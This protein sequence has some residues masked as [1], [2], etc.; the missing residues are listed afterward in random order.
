MDDFAAIV[1]SHQRMIFRVLA[2]MTGRFDVEDLAQEVFLRLFRALPAFRSEA[3]VATY[4]YRIAVNVATDDLRVQARD[5]RAVS[6]EDGNS[7]LGGRLGRMP[8]DY[9]AGMDRSRAR[10][11]LAGAYETLS[12]AE[13]S[14]VTLY[15]QEERRYEEIAA[16]LEMPVGTV[17]THLHR[18]R[19]KLKAAIQEKL[20]I[21]R[22]AK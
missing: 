17:K 16:I 22:T 3:N 6:L 13:R 14:V 18:A 8:P 2:R 15:F 10:A 7:S 19:G 20:A 1:E 21:C 9:A 12:A 11:A 5:R 4:L